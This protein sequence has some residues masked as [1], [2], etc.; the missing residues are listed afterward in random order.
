MRALITAAFAAL[1]IHMVP[2][3]GKGE[4]PTNQ[5]PLPPVEYAERNNVH[6]FW[7]G[8]PAGSEPGWGVGISHQGSRI[9]LTWLT[10]DTDGNPTWYVAPNVAW[11]KYQGNYSGRLYSTTAPPFD[12]VPW[13]PAKAKLVDVGEVSLKFTSETA[14][15]FH[16]KLAGGL[17]DSR[18]ISRYVFESPAPRCTWWSG[19]P[20]RS[21]NYTDTWWHAPFGNVAAW[22][23]NVAHQGDVLFVTW[24]TFGDDGKAEWIAMPAAIR[25]DTTT[26]SGTL[27]RM[28]GPP[29]AKGKWDASKV[30]AT[31]VGT[32]TL[33]FLGLDSASFTYTLDGVT[34]S[35]A[36]ARHLF[37]GP[38]TQ[39]E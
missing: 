3:W 38:Q 7:W 16:Y 8:S 33:F 22:G 31:P 11:Q 1:L 36:I 2:A 25:T 21:A 23:L 17:T 6:G 15:Y 27:Y 34:Q 32:A 29:P 37:D 5:K 12:E 28:H 30:S 13:N 35:K 14:G 19:G 18:P 10:Y 26:Y 20:L 24:F 39:C 9:T 4:F